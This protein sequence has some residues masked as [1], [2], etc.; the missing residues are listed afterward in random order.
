M[1]LDDHPNAV[2][3]TLIPPS[4]APLRF[5]TVFTNPVFSEPLDGS[6][7][8]AM[9]EREAQITVR[10]ATAQGDATL[11]PKLGQKMRLKTRFK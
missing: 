9:P 6:I 3:D 8:R 5:H 4:V 2:R 7:L 11:S 1:R 10:V